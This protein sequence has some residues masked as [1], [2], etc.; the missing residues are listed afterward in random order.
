MTN[1]ANWKL[2]G[3]LDGDLGPGFNY[4]AQREMLSLPMLNWKTDEGRT[5]IKMVYDMKFEKEG[6]FTCTVRCDTS[7]SDK[8]QGI[9]TETKIIAMMKAIQ[10]LFSIGKGFAGE[11]AEYEKRKDELAKTGVLPLSYIVNFEKDK[12]DEK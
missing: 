1:D 4:A 7:L 2:E 9:K 11:N 3:Q 6:K 8:N 12:K 5:P 10:E